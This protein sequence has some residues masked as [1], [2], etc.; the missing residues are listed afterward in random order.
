[1]ITGWMIDALLVV[2]Y[3]MVAVALLTAGYS[4]VNAWRKRDR[5][6]R[7]QNGVPTA[8]ITWAVVGGLVVILL[9]TFL[10]GSSETMIVNGKQYAEWLGLKVSDMFINTSLVL[11]FAAFVGLV[12][13]LTGWNRRL[14]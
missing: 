13:G 14:K 8:K 4:V 5:S 1:M 11:I 3:L 12:F 6:Q 7:V 10:F 2:M 9:L